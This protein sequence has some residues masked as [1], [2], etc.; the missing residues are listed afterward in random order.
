MKKHEDKLKAVSK[1]NKR[2]ITVTTLV[3]L[4][5]PATLG[6]IQAMADEVPTATTE[7]PATPVNEQPPSETQPTVESQSQE[8]VTPEQPVTETPSQE[9]TTSTEPVTEQPALKEEPTVAPT[10]TTTE[11]QTS[12]TQATTG[13]EAT[14]DVK[15]QAT[16]DEANKIEAQKSFDVEEA[17]FS[18]YLSQIKVILDEVEGKIITNPHRVKHD[19][20]ITC[21]HIASS[22]GNDTP[23]SSKDQA[24]YDKWLAELQSLLNESSQLKA[25][26]DASQTAEIYTYYV[27]RNVV[28]DN[29]NIVDST[30]WPETAVKDSFVKVEAINWY[31]YYLVPGTPSEYPETQITSDGTQEFVFYYMST[32]SEKH[33]DP[34][35]E[36]QIADL[37]EELYTLHGE[38]EPKAKGTKYEAP[39]QTI[40]YKFDDISHIQG[41][42]KQGDGW[43][44]W[45]DYSLPKLPA[46]L[47]ELKALANEINALQPPIKTDD[48][49]LEEAIKKGEDK[50]KEGGFETT[51]D[52]ENAIAK[53]KE[54]LQNDN[55]TQSEVDEASKQIS[56]AI[57]ALKKKDTGNNNGNGNN[58][59]NGNQNGN[60]QGGTNN[61]SNAGNNGANGNQNNG[62]NA[63]SGSNGATNQ[64]NGNKT[65]NGSGTTTNQ[66]TISKTVNNQTNSN[67]SNSNKKYPQTGEDINTSAL[68][69]GLSLVGFTTIGLLKRKRK[70]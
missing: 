52:L 46:I 21:W 53:G 61:G 5:C 38:L 7:Q 59:N 20:L 6:T 39:L 49:K 65:G 9:P 64:N 62:N 44:A 56:D 19:D 15:A 58:G 18:S 43:L 63:N 36:K 14:E 45:Y 23:S 27:V 50:L 48:S 55:R 28:D 34:A 40:Y 41:I 33:R 69:A 31:G 22:A 10:E 67:A 13:K 60:N 35:I 24:F 51:K 4:V 11:T 68:L 2:I 70:A 1:R 47:E 16:E 17:S 8:P 42:I 37:F 57:T 54:V 32:A 26:V 30:R 66:K 12:E 25:D 3:G 29:G